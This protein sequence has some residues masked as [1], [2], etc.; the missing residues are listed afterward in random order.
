MSPTLDVLWRDA[1]TN[2]RLTISKETQA[3]AGSYEEKIRDTFGLKFLDDYNA[4]N[5]AQ[6]WEYLGKAY[7]LGFFTA[8]RLWAEAQAPQP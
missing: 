4:I 7:E 5:D 8:F 1:I 3:E 2:C 6:L